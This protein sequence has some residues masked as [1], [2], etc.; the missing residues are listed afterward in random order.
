MYPRVARPKRLQRRV[1]SRGHIDMSLASTFP[2][3]GTELFHLH[4]VEAGRHASEG[5][6][7]EALRRIV[8]GMR[9]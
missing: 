4:R 1:T 2:Q 5:R 8:S 6:R 9:A 7:R 3:D